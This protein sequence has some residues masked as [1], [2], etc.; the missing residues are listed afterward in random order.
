MPVVLPRID[1]YL[2]NPSFEVTGGVLTGYSSGQT[3]PQR[4]TTWA[5]SGQYS[6][7]MTLA[8]YTGSISNPSQSVGFSTQPPVVPGEEVVFSLRYRRGPDG[9]WPA[10]KIFIN[11][12]QA[13]VIVSSPQP[14]DSG[15]VVP[16]ETGDGWG[17]LSVTAVMPDGADT[18][19]CYAYAYADGANVDELFVDG[20]MLTRKIAGPVPYGDGDAPGWAWTG[21]PHQSVSYRIPVEY[22]LP[23]I[24][25]GGAVGFEPTYS[26]SDKRGSRGE[27]LTPHMT[28]GRIVM[29]PDATPC[30][31]LT[32]RLD[33]HDIL[34][35]HLDY[36]RVDVTRVEADGSE[37]TYPLGHYRVV[38]VAPSHTTAGSTADFTANDMTEE[39]R[40][41]RYP[42]GVMLQAGLNYSDHIRAILVDGIGLDPDQVS[43]PGTAKLTPTSVWYEPGVSRLQIVNDMLNAVGMRNLYMD[44]FG[45]LTSSPSVELEQQTPVARYTSDDSM[46][47]TVTRPDGSTHERKRPHPMIGPVEEDPD[48]SRLRNR[49]TVRRTTP[50]SP[51]IYATVDNT[52]PGSPLSIDGPLG[53]LAGDPVDNPQLA[54]QAA[55]DAEAT[56]LISLGSSYY[57]RLSLAIIPDLAFGPFDVIE[58]DMVNDDGHVIDGRW[59]RRTVDLPLGPPVSAMAGGMRM[60]CNRVQ[61]FGTGGEAP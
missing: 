49:Q 32:G 12:Y 5:Y 52:N 21:P 54:D 40:R 24:G 47:E 57:N 43:I 61:A 55:A 6:Y 27:D 4:V 29:N 18:A 33:E 38:M 9:L 46:L 58:L 37:V 11:V 44:R 19:N 45:R 59:W 23:M 14:T 53:I 41:S 22:E 36:L 39:V 31:Q 56:K 15:A 42:G 26:R 10:A 34:T 3:P 30:W 1:N 20:F 2:T 7:R 50:G 8:D 35:R 17:I 48:D 16:P 13:T 51:T 25:S 28:G 60:Q